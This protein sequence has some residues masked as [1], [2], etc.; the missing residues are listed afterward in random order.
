MYVDGVHLGEKGKKNWL[1]DDY[2]KFIR[3]AQLEIERSD[4]GILGF[5]TNHGFIDNPTF[6]G[7]RVSLLRTFHQLAVL[8]LHGN[9]KKKEVCPDDTKDENVFS[10]CSD[11]SLRS[12]GWGCSFT[13]YPTGWAL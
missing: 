8:D 7:M 10:D 6:R 12:S 13:P 11:S 2:V 9:S 4:V 5:I 1:Q 3:Y